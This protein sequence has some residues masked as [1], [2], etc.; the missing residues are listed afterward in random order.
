MLGLA[1]SSISLR[2]QENAASVIELPTYTG[3]VSVAPNGRYFM[4]ED[5]TGFIVIGQNDAISWPGLNTL[6]DGSSAQAAEDYVRDLRAHGVTVSR[7]MIEYSQQPGSYLENPVGTFSEP[8][9]AFWDAFIPLAEEHGLYLLLT[10]YD[11]FWQSDHWETYPYNATMGGP[12]ETRTAWLMEPA[13]IDAQK[14]RWRFIIDRWGG[15]P[16]IFAWDLM[17]E[18]D[19]WWDAT[20]EDLAAYVDEMAAF[21]RDYELERW[22]YTHMLTVSSAQPVPEGALGRLIYDHPLLDFANTHL[23]IGDIADPADPILPGALMGG[24]VKLSLEAMDEPRPYFDSE[25]GPINDWIV[26]PEFDRVYHN[27]MSWAHLASCGAGT[28][29][30]WPYTNPHFILPELRDNLL[31]VA[32]FAS[33][34]DW[35]SFDSENISQQIRSSDRS[36]WRAGCADG[37]TGIIWLLADRR[38]DETITITGA[39]ITVSDVFG[40]GNYTVE[41]WDTSAGNVLAV[42]GVTVT[43]AT[44][45]LTIPELDTDLASLV[46]AVRAAME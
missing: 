27:N 31:A 11:T 46:L 16:N 42:D 23:Y 12:C 29:M 20:H 32:R 6:L 39:E 35:V 36:V 15:S 5:G 28:G 38:Q 22:G 18:I 4:D 1:A 25:S 8:V 24:G 30:R 40:D 34:I 33:T 19:L 7:I 41:Y 26:D 21:V 43:D 3:L 17:N 45:T 37:D 13:C 44:L 2:A 14:N 9:V 10:P